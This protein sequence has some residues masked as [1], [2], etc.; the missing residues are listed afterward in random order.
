V[1]VEIRAS[2]YALRYPC[3][4]IL[5]VDYSN[6]EIVHMGDICVDSEEMVESCRF[7]A[8]EYADGSAASERPFQYIVVRVEPLASF[9]S[10]DPRG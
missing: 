7:H 1:A 2:E 5:R 8:A 6:G 4:T 9:A 3:I 10:R